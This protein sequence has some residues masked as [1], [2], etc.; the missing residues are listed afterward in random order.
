VEW[1]DFIWF[2]T[3]IVSRYALRLGKAECYS[4]VGP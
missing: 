1:P 4:Q 2:E 3:R